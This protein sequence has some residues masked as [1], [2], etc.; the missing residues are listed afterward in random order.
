MT[1]VLQHLALGFVALLV[2]CSSGGGDAPTPPPDAGGASALEVTKKSPATLRAI[3]GAVTLTRD[4]KSATATTG[5]LYEKDVVETSDQS[6][7]T[8]RFSNGREVELGE[9]GRIEIGTTGDELV[10][11]VGQGIVVSRVGESGGAGDALGLTIDTPYG[12]VRVGSGGVSLNVQANEASVDV[13][14]GEV[15]LVGREGAAIP[16]EAGAGGTLSKRGASRTVTLEPLTIA[17]TQTSGRIELKKKDAKAFAPV[18]PKKP[19]PLGPGDSLRATS[20][21]AALTPEKSDAKVSLAPGAEVGIGESAKNQGVEELALELRKGQLQLSFPYGQKRVVKP[22]DGLTLTAPE[23]GVLT[24]TR[25]KNGLELSSV[26]GDVIV[27]TEGGPVTVK[28][29]QT[30]TLG[31][32]GVDA[33]DGSREALVLPSR[34]GLRLLHPGQERVALAWP[35]DDDKP[36]RLKVGLDAALEHPLIDGVVHHPFF[37]TVAPARGALFW[38]VFAGDEEL[39]KGSVSCAQEKLSGEL[40]ELTNEVA[41]SRPTT[42]IFFQDKPPS[43]TFT[44]KAPEKPAA[45]YLLKVYKAGALTTPIQEKRTTSTS[46]QLPPIPEGSYQWDVTYLD[47]SGTPIGT[48]GKLAALEVQ[49]D[50]AVRSLVIKSPR[51]GDPAGAKISVNGVAPLGAKVTAN[52]QPLSLD[53]KARFTGQVSPLPGARVAF[54]VVHQGAETIIVRW[55]GRGGAR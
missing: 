20:G 10:L 19:P 15:T 30:A 55:L 33:K 31:P 1:R 25:G 36:Y 50:N 4:G 32:S 40:D 21:T 39:A 51:N 18:N 42:R 2:G 48:M 7:A 44:W 6:N 41:S 13:L 54:R 43:L 38:K 35:G 47:A 16:L 45:E 5:P 49:Y 17:L 14:V 37:N 46:A 29:G 9:N 3:T 28:G 53:P 52:N 11:N 34:L 27:Q 24:V 26:V 22:G 23:G 8:L 12:L